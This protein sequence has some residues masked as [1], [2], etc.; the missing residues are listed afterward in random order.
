MQPAE[1]VLRRE[2]GCSAG[3]QF[4]IKNVPEGLET[5][6]S[7]EAMECAATGADGMAGTTTRGRMMQRIRNRGRSKRADAI[8]HRAGG[9]ISRTN[10]FT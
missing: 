8:R 4:G 6:Y 1:R 3:V 10:R 2:L 9:R 7:M 5:S